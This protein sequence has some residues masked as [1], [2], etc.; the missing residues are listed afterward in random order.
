MQDVIDKFDQWRNVNEATAVATVISTW[1][2]APRPVGSKMISSQ[3]G[4]IAGSVSAGCVEGAV[5]EE[6]VKVMKSRTPR[7]LTFGVADDQAF[8]VGLACGGT[9]QVF[10]ESGSAWDSIY[11]ELKRGL[12]ER[13]SFA[14]LTVI[15]GKPEL[16]NRKALIW[17]DGRVVGD[18]DIE[19]I[20]TEIKSKT[21]Q[22]LQAGESGVIEMPEDV[23]IFVEVHTPPPRLVIVG[24]VHLSEALIDIANVVGFDTILIDPRKAFATRERFPNAS[25]ILVEWPQDALAKTP[26]NRLSFIA[27]MTHDPKIDDPALQISLP[28]EAAYVGALGSKRTNQK[29]IERLR[30]AGISEEQIERLHAPIGIDLGGRSPGEIAVSIMAE[31]IKIHNQKSVTSHV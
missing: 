22:M 7:L 12:F 24:A 11:L 4:G 10:V 23:K 13:Q 3:G 28:S 14:V 30:S 8:D 26:L 31:I 9:I 29:R 21:E 16:Q 19:V 6:G 27:I 1:G 5:I 25:Q 17:E 15:S 18:L 2:S 20:S